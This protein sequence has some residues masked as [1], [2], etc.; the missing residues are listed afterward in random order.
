MKQE[1][2][3]PL[4][5]GS[6]SARAQGCICAVDDNNYGRGA[7]FDV[8]TGNPCFYIRADCPIH[9]FDPDD[10]KGKADGTH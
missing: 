3:D 1:N 10:K 5:P 2:L 7:F 8:E 6:K 9:G 4:Y